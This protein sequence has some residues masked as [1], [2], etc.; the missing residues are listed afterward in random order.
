MQTVL[1][2]ILFSVFIL[3]PYQ[4]GAEDSC[5]C[6]QLSCHSDCEYEDSVSFYSEKC[7]G[8]T[9]VRSCAKPRCLPLSPLPAQCKAD[10][11][12]GASSAASASSLA[13]TGGRSPASDS[14]GSAES[15][16]ERV[17]IVKE[18]EGRAW[19]RR[20]QKAL[21]LAVGLIVRQSD[22]IETESASKVMLVFNDGNSVVITESSVVELSQF[23]FNE[24]I[25]KRNTLLHLMKGKVRSSVKQKYTGR[26]QSFF[27]V[28]TPVAVAGVRGTDFIVSFDMIGADLVSDVK[29]LTGEVEFR[30]QV[31][32]QAT[33]V[34]REQKTKIVLRGGGR[35]LGDDGQLGAGDWRGRVTLH[36]VSGLEK[37]EVRRVE[38]ETVFSALSEE[39]KHRRIASLEA[40]EEICQSP[41]A[42]VN[43]CSWKCE[44]NP[45]GETTCRADLPGVNCVR[46]MCNGNGKW[47]DTL[48]LPASFSLAC[49]PV[50]TLVGPCDY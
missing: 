46:R 47:A 29:T 28:K 8:G 32:T 9:R 18:L 37:D 50:K 7:A 38:A 33:V 39:E 14:A 31:D 20:E 1:K 6:P 5:A 10:A 19:V 12:P 16:H 24:E 41:A 17:G 43:Q 23:S 27:Q 3:T 4:S 49:D 30:S 36:P 2:L 13:D 26:D 11:A 35:A 25:T 48:R 15:E 42:K 45:K 21:A 40:A 22:R 44:N 34:A